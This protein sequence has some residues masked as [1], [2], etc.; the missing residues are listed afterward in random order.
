MLL[1]CHWSSVGVEGESVRRRWVVLE[2]VSY[3]RCGQGARVLTS[4]R[5]VLPPP[6]ARGVTNPRPTVVDSR[7]GLRSRQ[8]RWTWGGLTALMVLASYGLILLEN[9]RF[10]YSDD[11]ESGAVPNWIA[12]GRLLRSGELPSISPNQWMGGN[13]GVEGQGGLWNPVQVII[14]LIAPSV[15]NLSLFSATVKFGFALILALGAYRVALEYGARPPWAALAGAAVPL[16]G[17]SLFYDEASWVTALTSMAWVAQAWASALRYA[18]ARSGP[19]PT[20]AFFYL[21]ISVGYPH[22]AI[23]AGL[24]TACLVIGERINQGG[25]APGLKLAAAAAAAAACGVLTFLPGLLSSSV[26]WRSGQGNLYNDNFLTAPWS[27]TLTASLPSGVPSIQAWFGE[28][29]PWPVTYV[30][31]FLI[32]ALALIDWAG[33][34]RSLRSLSSALMFLGVMFVMTDGPSSLGPLRWPARWLPFVAMTMLVVVCVLLSKHGIRRP[35]RARLGA[36]CLIVAVQVLRG[37]SANPDLLR[38]HVLIGVA[39]AVGGAG[40]VFVARTSRHQ[41]VAVALIL[42]S[43]PVLWF[44]I[45]RY[46]YQSAWNLP[47]SVSQAQTAFPDYAGLTLQ[48]GSRDLVRDQDR[49]VNGAWS[50]LVFGN[51]AKT[52]NLDY[53]NSYTSIGYAAFSSLLCMGYDGSTCPDAYRKLFSVEPTTG[54]NYADLM[55]LD[56]V[57]LQRSQY[58]SVIGQPAPSGWRWQGGDYSSVVLIRSI[59]VFRTDGRVVSTR[60]ATTRLVAESDASGSYQVSSPSGGNVVF[61]R[62]AWPGYHASIDGTPVP[63][64]AVAGVFLAVE[65]PA[66]TRGVLTVSFEPPGTSLGLAGVAFGILTIAVLSGLHIRGRRRSQRAVG[67]DEP[68]GAANLAG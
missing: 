65:V 9:K 57:V 59:P 4:D 55:M 24:L 45:T 16:A 51:Y 8:Q 29:Q 46:P 1:G 25:W 40:I 34:R 20:F 60:D 49:S 68:E 41:I 48:L 67:S 44:Q 62:L 50:S 13:W 5:P 11:T 66:G 53:V 39:M 36:A 52:L 26:T 64:S 19:V 12:L 56:R 18:R 7:T 22:A 2:T 23:A 14:N 58:P 28:V 21:A 47:T 17:F 10:F 61:A 3:I 15:D 6:S 27:E 35:S 54:R 42:S 31:W 37:F 38:R 43:L 32:P 33:A 63:V 30:A